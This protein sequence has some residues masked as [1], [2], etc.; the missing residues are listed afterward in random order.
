MTDI[1]IKL[2]E[3]S[4]SASAAVV[5][6]LLIRPMMRRTPKYIRCILWAVVG[7]RLLVPFTLETKISPIPKS[8]SVAVD[9]TAVETLKKSAEKTA[10]L[11][12]LTGIL[13]VVFH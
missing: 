12:S 4:V 1:F 2:A 13:T 11:Y 8:P 3:M 6:I 7:L 10:S 9:R 5:I